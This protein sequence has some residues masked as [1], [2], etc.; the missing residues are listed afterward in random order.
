MSLVNF[1]I[2]SQSENS[3]VL[4]ISCKT[5]C[6]PHSL[7]KAC[8][9]NKL[10]YSKVGYVIAVSSYS[11]LTPHQALTGSKTSMIETLTTGV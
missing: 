1:I 4:L 11:A 2:D 6:D 3:L 9:K 5:D 7:G 10:V 8:L